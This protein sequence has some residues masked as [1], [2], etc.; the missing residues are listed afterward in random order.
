[1]GAYSTAKP[2]DDRTLNNED[3]AMTQDQKAGL[4]RRA[5]YAAVSVA[6]ILIL[7]KFIAFLLTGSVS[8]LSSLLDSV[9]DSLASIVN[10]FA[11]RHALEPADREHRF[12]HGKAEPLAGLAQAAFVLGSSLFLIVEAC[13]RFIN[14]QL[15]E[16]GGLG[17]AIMLVSLLM[18]IALVSYQRH[19]VRETGSLAIK[20]DSIH[21]LSDIVLNIGV[22]LALIL[23]TSFGWAYAEPCFALLVAVYIVH[24]A[25]RIIKQSLDQLMDRELLDSDRQKI[26]EIINS[27]SG[28]MGLHDLRTRASGKDV[29]IQAHIDID[30][31]MS[32]SAAHEISET[33]EEKLRQ[34][35]PSA[36]IIIH[37]DPVDN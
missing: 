17:I 22:I 15:V 10:L 11:V 2:A 30:G 33:V 3:R 1:M 18:T 24:S 5:T 19:V 31:N 37:Q 13:N 32:L 16:K 14:P 23:S 35:F 21:Y 7:I 8:L 36:D 20:A 34:A 28:V 29:F 9:L 4:L 25:W 6:S 26:K 27:Q 12:G